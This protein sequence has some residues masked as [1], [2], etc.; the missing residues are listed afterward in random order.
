[1]TTTCEKC[2]SDKMIPDV[3]VVDRGDGN[4]KWELQVVID[5]NPQA[6]LFKD[7]LYGVLKAHICG[8]CGHTELTV[9]N[10]QEL[11]RKYLKTRESSD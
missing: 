1:M 8:E 5:G 11:Y 3:K 2:G 10:P 6:I 7:R 4:A 9:D